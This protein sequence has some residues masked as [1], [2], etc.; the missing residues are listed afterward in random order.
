M[1][2]KMLKGIREGLVKSF[3]LALEES[4]RT[5]SCFQ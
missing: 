5:L 1:T 3:A 2:F 4:V